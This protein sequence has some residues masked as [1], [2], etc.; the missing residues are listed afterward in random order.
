MVNIFWR[1]LELV[2][3]LLW[4]QQLRFF[5]PSLFLKGKL[6]REGET[7][8]LQAILYWNIPMVM[9][10]SSRPQ[11]VLSKSWN[12][13]QKSLLKIMVALIS[14]FGICRCSFSIWCSLKDSPETLTSFAVLQLMSQKLK[15]HRNFGCLLQPSGLLSGREI[16]W[17]DLLVTYS[18]TNK[19]HTINKKY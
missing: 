7:D 12:P 3:H 9:H 19:N 17:A 6:I 2:C 13:E 15:R 18:E 16:V 10:T 11:D 8:L 5:F 4:M 1:W 14:G